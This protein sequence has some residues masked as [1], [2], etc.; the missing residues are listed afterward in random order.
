[1]SE[2]LSATL[3]SLLKP[4]VTL[5]KLST[6]KSSKVLKPVKSAFDTI[7]DVLISVASFRSAFVAFVR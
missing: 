4:P 5:L 7:V 3:F 1:M 2:S 6:S